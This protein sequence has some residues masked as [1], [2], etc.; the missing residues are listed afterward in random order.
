MVRM[1]AVD[2]LTDMGFRVE[3]AGSAAEA[4][5]KMRGAS[6]RFDAA[7]ID[8]G[9]PDIKGDKLAGE[10]RAIRADMPMLIAS[11]YD[12]EYI[13][14]QFAG[15]AHVGVVP[16]PYDGDDLRRELEKLGVLT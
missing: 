7:I 8:I 6:E 9:L 12:V 2:I 10:L 5:S 13:R 4:L 3:E 15:H 11:G 1:V 16:K 14:D